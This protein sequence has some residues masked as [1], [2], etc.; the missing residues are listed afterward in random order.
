MAAFG[1]YTILPKPIGEESLVYEQE[2]MLEVRFHSN[3]F[4]LGYSVG[5][6][7]TWYRT[8]F[9]YFDI[10]ALKNPKEHSQ[11]FKFFNT[12]FFNESSKPFVYGKQNRLYTIRAGLGT[13]RLFSEKAR[14]KS[15]I[16][17]WSYEYGF[18][19]GILKPYYLKLRN[20]ADVDQEIT[21]EKYSEEN[22]DRFLDESSIFGGAEF[23]YGL[24]E[25]KIRPGIHGKAGMNFSWGDNER[26]IKAIEVGVM[27][28][29][30]L[31]KVPIMV[32]EKN[33]PYFLNVYITLQI[34]KR[35]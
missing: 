11:N 3:G 34:G 25:L 10:G 18:T 26:L 27:L 24:D 23:R 20:W 17:G 35:S 28:D 9:Y 22:A 15:I 13:K 21:V 1:Q 31:G 14:K 7:E 16:V 19:L 5:R 29:L 6:I 2:K 30:F 32:L 33:N 12:G 8:R 4:S